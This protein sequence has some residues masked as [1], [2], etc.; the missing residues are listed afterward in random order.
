MPSLIIS[1][2]FWTQLTVINEEKRRFNKLITEGDSLR[3][4]GSRLYGNILTEMKNII[5]GDT[6]LKGTL[7]Q[8]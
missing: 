6:S 8:I 5:S 7:M 4:M 1:H 3:P 2:L